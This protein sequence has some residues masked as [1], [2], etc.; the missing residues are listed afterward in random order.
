MAATPLAITIG[1]RRIVI[2]VLSYELVTAIHFALHMQLGM[3]QT[4]APVIRD[5]IPVG[6]D[7]YT[8]YPELLQASRLWFHFE[9]A[10][11]FNAPRF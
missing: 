1:L 5:G 2:V 7:V 11:L 10:E 9:V 8:D 6:I 3:I 4:A